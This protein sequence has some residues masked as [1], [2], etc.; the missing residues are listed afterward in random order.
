MSVFWAIVVAVAFFAIVVAL[1]VAGGRYLE[2][3]DG[4]E[5]REREQGELPSS[6]DRVEDEGERRLEERRRA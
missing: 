6:Q 3:D 4:R 1:V 2:R 5:Q